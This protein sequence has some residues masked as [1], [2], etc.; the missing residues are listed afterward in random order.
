M[1]T[2]KEIERFEESKLAPYA[3]KSSRTRGRDIKESEH[4]YR[5]AFQ[6]DRDRI[7]YCNAFRRLQYKTQVFVNHEGDYYR[8]RLT[9][10]M[11]VAQISRTI[12]RTLNLNEDLAETV[13]LAHD[14]GHTPFGHSGEEALHGLMKDKGGFEHNSQGIRVVE[15][16]EERYPQFKGLN[17]SWEIRESMRKH[18]TAYDN[19][20]MES[21]FEPDWEPLLE[22]Q[23]VDQADSIAYDNHDL[24]DSLMARLINEE[25]LAEIE[26]WD[27][28]YKHI[29]KLYP[30]A[31]RGVKI[32]QTIIHLINMQVSDLL[33]NTTGNIREFGIKDVRG[34]RECG[35]RIMTFSPGMRKRKEELEKFM[36]RR[37]YRHHKVVQMSEKAKRFIEELFA[38][39]S[40]HPEQLPPK[41]QIWAERVGVERSV[42]DYIAGMTDRFAQDEY[43]RLFYPFENII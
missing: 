28:A 40:N 36:Y 6:R 25:A 7:I 20:I 37:V 12:A 41:W 16:L 2:R 13:A 11:E 24:D 43:K 31:S 17:L 18:K 9:H 23:V 30:F 22:A 32:N 34:V 15:L 8:T 33:K 21:R 10:T 38:T 29:K 26:L 19:P 14:L 42:S 4:D 39:F 35:Q 27:K 1:L 5:T 3:M